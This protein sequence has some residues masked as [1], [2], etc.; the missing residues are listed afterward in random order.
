MVME[1]CPCDL[2]SLLRKHHTRIPERIIKGLLQQTLRGLA[3]CH[4]A[5][6]GQAGSQ[7]PMSLCLPVK[8]QTHNNATCMH[9]SQYLAPGASAAAP[10]SNS[11]LPAR[12][13]PGLPTPVMLGWGV[14]LQVAPTLHFVTSLHVMLCRHPAPGPEALQHPAEC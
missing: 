14:Q 7:L 9:L 13:Q 11:S 8:H 6:R 10:P 1:Y 4:A 2:A 5:G 12:H 3:A